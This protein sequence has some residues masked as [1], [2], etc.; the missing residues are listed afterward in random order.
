M[1]GGKGSDG[2]IVIKYKTTKYVK[3]I[4]ETKLIAT[5]TITNTVNILEPIVIPILYSNERQYPPSRDLTSSSHIISGKTYGNG[6][7]E[8]WDSS[9]ASAYVA[10]NGSGGIGYHNNNS[11]YTG[12]TYNGSE[13][14][15]SDY[16]GDWIK[17]KLP[18][19]INLTKYG[20]KQ[21]GG[22]YEAR[23][24]GSF[25][26]YGSNND[27]TWYKLVER[28]YSDISYSLTVTESNDYFEENIST[29]NCYNYFVLVVNKTYGGGTIPLNF[30]E[31]NI[32]GK[33]ENLIDETLIYNHIE[34]TNNNTEYILNLEEDTLCDILIV[35]GG[36]SGGNY[37]GGGG[38]GDALYFSGIKLKKNIKYNILVGN[39]G[40][41]NSRL[42]ST[43]GGGYSGNN[44]SLIGEGLNIIAG[45]GGGGGGYN[46]QGI[47]GTLVSFINPI[48]KKIQ[49]SSGG[50]GGEIQNNISRSGN[51]ISGDGASNL[52]SNA[53]G[54]GGGGCGEIIDG[55]TG[56]APDKPS[57]NLPGEGG[58]GYIN[59]ISG[60]LVK[61]GG[62]GGGGD[63]TSASVGGTASYGGGAGSGEGANNHPENGMPNTGGGGGGRGTTNSSDLYGRGGSGVVI[64]RK[65]KTNKFTDNTIS[66]KKYPSTP[67]SNSD[68]WLDSS[69]I[70]KCKSSDLILTN[71]NVY[72][73]FN[74]KISSNDHYHSAASLYNSSGVYTGTTTF[75][76]TSGIVLFIDLGQSIYVRKMK[77][78][79]RDQTNHALNF[80]SGMPN[81][82]EIWA[83]NDYYCWDDND[84][85]SWIK[86]H[87]QETLLN[88]YYGV[89]TNFG[90]FSGISVPYR[91]FAMVVKS[92]P[93]PSYSYLVISEWE[94]Y[95]EVKAPIAK[96]FYSQKSNIYSYNLEYNANIK[97][98]LSGWQHVGHLPDGLAATNNWYPINT[99]KGNITHGINKD[100]SNTWVIPFSNKDE[101][102]FVKGDFERWAYC[103]LDKLNNPSL[104]SWQKFYA[105][106]SQTRSDGLPV[107]QIAVLMNY[108]TFDTYDPFI[109]LGKDYD[110]ENTTTGIPKSSFD[111]GEWLYMEPHDAV[112]NSSTVSWKRDANTTYDIFVRNSAD[113]SIKTQEYCILECDATN[114]KSWYKFDN[115]Y[116][117]EINN[118]SI[119]GSKNSTFSD[120]SIIYKSVKIPHGEIIKI[121]N[122][123]CSPLFSGVH[124]GN[125]LAFW[126]K[127]DIDTANLL[128]AHK[129]GSP[130]D[131]YMIQHHGANRIYWTRQDDRISDFAGLSVYFTPPIDMWNNWHHMALVGDWDGTN[132]ISR[133]YLDGIE[134][135]LIIGS[136]GI[137]SWSNPLQYLD[138][139][140]LR[141]GGTL[142]PDGYEINDGIQYFEDLRI[143]DKA[144][145]KN[146]IDILCKN[147]IK[148]DEKILTFT[149]KNSKTIN[150]VYIYPI[151]PGMEW[152]EAYKYAISLGGRLATSE[153]A[154]EYVSSSSYVQP[155]LG[156]RFHSGQVYAWCTDVDANL[157]EQPELINLVGTGNVGYLLWGPTGNRTNM[158]SYT[159]HI[160]WGGNFIVVVYDNIYDSEYTINF[161]EDTECDILI[162]GGGGGG[163]ADRAGGGG[164]GACIV[165]PNYIMNG[166]YKIKVGNGGLG[167]VTT[168]NNSTNGEDSKITNLNESIVFFKAKGG[169]GGS[170]IA[171]VS[172]PQ[173]G[174]CGGGSRSQSIYNGG[175]AVNTNIVNI[176]ETGPNITSKYAVYGNIGGRNITSYT[177]SQHDMDGAGG[178]GIGEGGS[179]TGSL[180]P[181]DSQYI[182]NN[183]G[184]GGNGLYKSTIN[185]IDYD[186]KNHFNTG[187]LESDGNYYI[188]GGGGGGDNYNGV[189]GNGGKGGG[190]RGGDSGGLKTSN[191]IQ[192]TGGGG[193]GGAGE[194]NNN[195][196]NGGS[197][198]VIIK[199]KTK[200]IIK[201]TK[202]TLYVANKII[203]DENKYIEF[204]F[205]GHANKPKLADLD[206]Y[207]VYFDRTDISN[208]STWDF[209]A[210][211]DNDKYILDRI[212][213]NK[214][215]IINEN[216]NAY[217]KF[218]LKYTGIPIRGAIGMDD[219]YNKRKYNNN[220]L[221][222]IEDQESPPLI[223]DLYTDERIYPPV[224]NLTSSQHTISNADYGNGLYEIAESESDGGGIEIRDGFC[225][226]NTSKVV[227]LVVNYTNTGT[228]NAEHF[229]VSDYKGDWI[230]I[231]MPV[232]IKLTKYSLK[233]RPPPYDHRAPGKYKIYGSNNGINWTELVHKT[234][235]ITYTNYVFEENINTIELYNHFGLVVS[236][237]MGTGSYLLNLNEWYIYGKEIII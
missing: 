88:Y 181:V 221:I 223:T 124:S 165:Y 198:I 125:T 40:I 227:S 9:N 38:G 11:N 109:L 187:I 67:S 55:K 164:A 204:N 208:N 89:L 226:F 91:Y 13:Y 14:I 183:P 65:H 170:S 60:T 102:L 235:K 140:Y 196:G 153:E 175:I 210:Y 76:G 158:S 171:L 61:Y 220:Y 63:W 216:N 178:G 33:E 15:V 18:V 193:G 132:I 203:I 8:T 86:I 168:S 147:K 27:I 107:T 105:V 50:G 28:E 152:G 81:K 166:S 83:S 116:N 100:N 135:S 59:D 133:I 80:I 186:F 92:L 128:G 6:L 148:D 22:S 31:W 142:H 12:R 143:Y 228:Y 169:G 234:S 123:A 17:I 236:E 179:K 26:I 4:N 150:H 190:G 70:V 103:D 217:L 5:K 62:G 188:G 214:N 184:K 194:T 114:L 120:D 144:L 160:D 205:K 46:A 229:L 207:R 172:Q 199:Y 68:K 99:L 37:G 163:G 119:I 209:I 159:S 2:I 201:D 218:N 101:I 87:T 115:T 173:D 224:Y 113:N 57:A 134:Q 232:S 54:G 137:Q 185:S 69:L 29:I 25:K 189:G 56:N 82:F 73:L 79:P 23:A 71:E 138:N 118:Y 39:G 202:D 34:G 233:L 213:H 72:Y 30:D 98:G 32:F 155:D 230:T 36:G 111:S 192:N 131:R 95:G 122:Q 156:E 161:P 19:S 197:G 222:N 108:S 151:D 85:F 145:T 141:L 219:L 78:A 200:K 211:S 58:K 106:T 110:A 174:G 97:T 90:T 117:D 64:I 77:I 139:E 112:G 24:P 129:L 182:S 215:N 126:F 74:N 237:L 96:Q 94:I 35:G 43:H 231:K 75:K 104:S 177:G 7:Y 195:G 20:F 167:A 130:Y 162:I 10:F 51:G 225:A 53:A 191:G 44:S 16:L 42:H 1:S 136:T 49:Y 206:E 66:L 48:T 157:N 45:G 121:P 127:A 149:H 84:H 3:K 212:T 93:N 180:V 21:R 176:I 146:E 154:E 52:D 41:G 47:D